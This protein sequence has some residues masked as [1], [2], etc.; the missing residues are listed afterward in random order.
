[1]SFALRA[2]VFLRRGILD[3]LLAAGG[4]PGWDQ[5]LTLRAAQVTAARRRR[6][7]AESL[8]RA[9]HDA[10]RPPRWTCAAPLDRDAVRAAAPELHALAAGLAE[11]PAPAA[12]GVA[13]AEQLLRDPGSPLYA[14]GDEDALRAGAAIAQE[15]LG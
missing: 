8:E 15:A 12:Q 4:D 6:A 1:M 13:L 14:P 11:D 10:H 7:L 3:R 2:H 5:T 9:I